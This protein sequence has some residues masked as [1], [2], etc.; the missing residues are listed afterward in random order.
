MIGV[1]GVG[2]VEVVMFEDGTDAGERVEEG[3]GC[4][5]WVVFEFEGI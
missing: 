1:V 3:D 5:R 4:E 2:V